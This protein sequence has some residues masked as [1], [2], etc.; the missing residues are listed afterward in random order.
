VLLDVR[1][2]RC[3]PGRVPAQLEI[4]KKYGYPVQLRYMG[5]PLC[6]EVAESGELNTFTH[7]WVYES[8]ADREQK[9]AKMAADP[10]WKHF[11]SENAKA[12]NVIDQRNSLMVPAPF[13]PKIPP[14]KIVK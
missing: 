3:L 13:S 7:V 12:G 1:T 9:R 2:Y 6:Y 14:A 8:A 5:E 4:Y 11:L 10:D